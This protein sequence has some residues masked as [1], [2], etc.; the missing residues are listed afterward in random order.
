[1][2]KIILVTGSAGFIGFHV[3]KLLLKNN[4]NVIGVDNLNNYYYANNN[5]NFKKTLK[6]FL[7]SKG[8]SFFE[9]ITDSISLKD[10]TRPKNLI[11]IKKNFLNS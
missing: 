10:L 4:Y 11:D 5:S 7:N 6:R 9:I 3:S 2:K 8:P 1:M